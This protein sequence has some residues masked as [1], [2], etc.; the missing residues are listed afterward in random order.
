M[1]SLCLL[2]VH[3]DEYDAHNWQN[4]DGH[5]TSQPSRLLEHDFED[6]Q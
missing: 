3:G 4:E 6:H 2:P 5:L 1:R